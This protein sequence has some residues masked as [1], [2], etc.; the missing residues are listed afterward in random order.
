MENCSDKDSK[1]EY[2]LLLENILCEG[3]PYRAI[4]SVPTGAIRSV[5]IGAIT[6]PKGNIEF[7][8]VATALTELLR[9]STEWLTRGLPLGYRPPDRYLFYEECIK[10]N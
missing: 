8:S 5:P 9:F 10:R 1:P 3:R 4:R 2:R 7:D 6:Q